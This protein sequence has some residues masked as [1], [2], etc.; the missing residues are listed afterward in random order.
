MPQHCPEQ[1]LRP[2]ETQDG[3]VA[4]M[5]AERD[6]F[7]LTEQPIVISIVKEL[8]SNAKDHHFYNVQ[9]RGKIVYLNS[10]TI[11]QYYNLPGVEYDEYAKY[12]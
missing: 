8:Y 6:W 1:G 2:D 3:E 5:I 7:A 12:V 10:E 11:N 4:V 9:V